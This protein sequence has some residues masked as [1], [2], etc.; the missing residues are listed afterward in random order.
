MATSTCSDKVHCL[1][2]TSRSAVTVERRYKLHDRQL[3][4]YISRKQTVR[5]I[6]IGLL[7]CVFHSDLIHRIYIAL[8][9]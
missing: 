6:I 3:V 5:D 8:R 1:C 2:V 4:D 9:Y 7:I